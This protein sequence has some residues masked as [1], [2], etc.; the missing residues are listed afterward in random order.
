MHSLK[1][2]TTGESATTT[3]KQVIANPASLLLQRLANG[4]NA[5]TQANC[6]KLQSP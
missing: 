2:I 5:G 1:I 4:R 6:R 3:S